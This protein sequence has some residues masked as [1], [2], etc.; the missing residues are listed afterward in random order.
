M[1][2]LL[3][4]DVPKLGRRGEVVNVASGYA[5]N[6]LIPQGLAI[7]VDPGNVKLVEAERH[8]I[9]M[10][11]RHRLDDLRSISEQ[12]SQVSV[13]IRANATEEGHLFGSVTERDV[14]EAL[15]GENF[16]ITETMVRMESHL[17]ELG[18]FEVKVHL[19]DEVEATVKV[20]VTPAE[21]EATA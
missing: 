11:E 12:L 8:R 6:Y 1:E 14:A 17:K 5:R 16:S 10:V 21:E 13:T 2:L 15:K 18:M 19:D 4:D 20:W 7:K 9:A 3:R